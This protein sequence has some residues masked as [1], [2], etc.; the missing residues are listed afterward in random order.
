MATARAGLGAGASLNPKE[1]ARATARAV[2]KTATQARTSASRDVRKQGYNLRA[3]TIRKA[4]ALRRANPAKPAATLRATGRPVPLIDYG[5]RQTKNGVSVRVKNGRTVLRHAFIATMESGHK[6]VFERVSKTAH[7]RVS[8]NGKTYWSGLP[9][10]ELFG[11]SIPDALANSTVEKAMTRLLET[12][13][14]AIL[15]HEISRL[16]H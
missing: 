16:Q 11:P 3:S 8:K 14:P 1:L 6:G 13:F 5:A 9:I 2:N 15:A 7:R 10:R 12:K 4:L